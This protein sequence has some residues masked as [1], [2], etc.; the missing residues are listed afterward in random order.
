MNPAEQCHSQA[1]IPVW[2]TTFSKNVG[3]VQKSRKRVVK[4]LCNEPC[5]GCSPQ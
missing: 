1:V 4:A 2:Q 3:V 5:A